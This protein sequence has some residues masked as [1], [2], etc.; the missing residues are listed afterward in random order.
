M[1]TTILFMI[2]GAFLYPLG[3][4]IGYYFSIWR[5][6]AK[7]Y[8]VTDLSPKKWIGLFG[9]TMNN[10]MLRNSS[11][12]YFGE[13]YLI[14]SYSGL[15]RIIAPQIQ[16][17]YQDIRLGKECYVICNKEKTVEFSLKIDSGPSVA[18]N[19]KIGGLNRRP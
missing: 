17:S 15:G 13:K 18:L 11:K 9:L 10:L 6:A 14:I 8:P 4:F 1:I 5:I 2:L 3:I 16:V 7:R 19:K 12:I